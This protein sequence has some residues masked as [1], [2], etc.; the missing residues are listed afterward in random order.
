M[1]GLWKATMRAMATR[2]PRNEPMKP[3]MTASGANGKMAGQST[4]GRASGMSFSEMPTKAA[5]IS[6]MN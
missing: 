3:M 2:P 6:A 1:V 5:V 4:A